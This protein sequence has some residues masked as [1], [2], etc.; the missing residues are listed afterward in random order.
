[1]SGLALGFMMHTVLLAAGPQT[2]DEAYKQAQANGQP[3]LVLVG[4]DW[5]PGCRT[6]KSA[7]MPRLAQGGKLKAVNLALVNSDQNAALAAILMR[8][9]SI[10]QLIV[11]AKTETGW[12][13]E[14]ITGA[15]S[16]AA[17]EQL[18]KRATDAQAAAKLAKEKAAK[19]RGTEAA[20]GGQ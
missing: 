20:A 9:N 11:Y 18:I 3:I 8:G 10:P 17:V 6:M 15:T 1:M 13:R 7:V 19:E 2:Y 14:Q 12:H 5:C 16:E 4:A